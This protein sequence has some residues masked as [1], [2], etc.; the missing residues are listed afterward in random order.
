MNLRRVADDH[1]DGH[2]FAQRAAQAENDGAD[3]AD[4][5]VAQDAHADHLPARGAQRQHRFALRVGHGRHHLARKRGDDG[6]D[7]D[8]E[9]DAGGEIA[10]SGGIVVGEEA[11][12]A[13]RL[14]EHRIHVLAQQGNEDEDSPQAIDDAG[15]GGQQLG[16]KGQRA[17]QKAGAHFGE[18]DGDAD[19]QRHRH[20]QRQERGNQRAIDER[21]GAEVAVDRIPI[22]RQAGGRIEVG[23]E[24]ELKAE[25]APGQY[26]SCAPT[27]WQ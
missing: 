24:E 20:Q 21:Q 26:E 5:R 19:G 11:R 9:N 3:N 25:R 1:G 13:E 15:N 4:A 6:Q 12:P 17:A 14:N 23:A 8:G 22:R 10:K 27:P 2:G 18:E 16:K 7:H